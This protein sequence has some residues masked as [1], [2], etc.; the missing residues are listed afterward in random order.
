MNKLDAHMILSKRY[1]DLQEEIQEIEEE[2]DELMEEIN[3]REKEMW[4]LKE[5]IENANFRI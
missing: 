1:F 5:V 3:D 4:A 2:I